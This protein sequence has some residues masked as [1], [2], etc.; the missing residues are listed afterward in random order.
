MDPDGGSGASN[1]RGKH[2]AP[3]A[4]MEI[5]AIWPAA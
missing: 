1:Y 3:P 2:R 4:Q 5:P